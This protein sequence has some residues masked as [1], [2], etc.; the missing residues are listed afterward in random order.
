MF[1]QNV[2]GYSSFI[3]QGRQ[4]KDHISIETLKG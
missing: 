4:K 1:V 2:K 3:L